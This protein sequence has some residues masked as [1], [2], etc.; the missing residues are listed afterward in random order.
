MDCSVRPGGSPTGL[1]DREYMDWF[2]RVVD[3]PRNLDRFLAEDAEMASLVS[4]LG[5][6]GLAMADVLAHERRTDALGQRDR[7]GVE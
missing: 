6:L 2:R 1:D 4:D 5:E 7:T 3:A